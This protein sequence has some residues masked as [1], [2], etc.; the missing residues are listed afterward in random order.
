MSLPNIQQ[1][2]E[3]TIYEAFR[4][5]LVKEGYLPDINLFDVENEELE[6]AKAAQKAYLEA[7]ANIADGPKGFAIEL[8]SNSTAQQRGQLKTPRIVLETEGF[9]PGE[10]GIDTTPKYIK[11]QEGKYTVVNAPSET[12]DLFFAV[13]LVANNTKQIRIL[14]GVNAVT[15][16]RR[17]YL[18]WHDKEFMRSGNLFFKYISFYQNEFPEEGIIEKIYRY[19]VPDVHEIDDLPIGI[20]PPIIEID[21]NED[22]YTL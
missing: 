14:H 12:S 17:G 16:P 10:L 19:M 2:L 22:K 4:V 1:E 7:I 9:Y 5:T 13:R 21:F 6:I 15:L 11:N 20:A 3:R 8:F 18:G